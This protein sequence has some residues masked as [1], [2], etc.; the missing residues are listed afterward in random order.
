MREI[1]DGKF[2]RATDTKSLE[3]SIEEIDKLEKSKVSVK[4]YQQYRDLFPVCIA[5][6]VRIADRAVAAVA[7]DLEDGCRDGEVIKIDMSFGA[8]QWFWGLLVLP[9]CSCCFMFARERRSTVLLQQFIS[10]RFW[11]QLAGNVD[12]FRRALRFAL[13]LLGVS[14]SP[15]WR[16]PGRAGVTPTRM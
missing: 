2:Y 11:P 16:W 1:A 7:N 6:G 8:P 13:L 12:R 15:S 14:R 10:P 9:D 3:R 4:K 5:A